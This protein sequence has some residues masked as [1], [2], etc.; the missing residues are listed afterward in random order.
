MKV[1]VIGAGASGMMAA[2]AAAMNGNEV[3]VYEKNEKCGKKIYITGKGRCNITNDVPPQEFL[4]NVVTNPK[5]LT[6]AI[7]SFSS[8]DTVAF[9]ENNGLRVKTERG[10]RVFPLSDKSSDVIK[11]LETACRNAGV[12][13]NFNSKI[14]NISIISSTVSDI[15]VNNNRILCDK[16]I[17]CTGGVSY[18]STGSTGDGLNFAKAAGHNIIPVKPALC[19]LNL[20]GNYFGALQGLSLKNVGLN[21]IYN[22]KV[23]RS[24]FGEMLFTHFGVSGPV[25]LSASSHM[26]NP[27]KH[28]YKLFIDLKPALDFDTLDKRVQRDF[29]ENH[30]RDYINSLSKLLP[31]KL[32]PIIVSLSKIPPSLKVNQITKEQRTALVHL[33]KNFEVDIVRFRPIDEAIITSGGVSVKEI[34]PKTMQSKL[35]DNLYFAGE[36]IDV[37]AYTGGFN[38]QIAFS[39]GYL[40]G[41]NM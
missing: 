26:Q 23:L 1:A 12:K 8:D 37:D 9:F 13:F 24:L 29:L 19:G 3:T 2:Y 17:V 28:K 39:T 35:V 18:P 27:E 41:K 15:I 38:L 32:I 7:Y 40:C 4:Q 25:I 33:I 31:N 36:V 16:V 30:N 21:I 20:K 6:G 14:D 5:F 34:N 10:N 11:C 22:G